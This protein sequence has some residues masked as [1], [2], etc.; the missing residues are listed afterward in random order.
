M[1]VSLPQCTSQQI[2]GVTDTTLL[3]SL[4][5]E[6]SVAQ[7]LQEALEVLNILNDDGYG[8]GRQDEGET[9]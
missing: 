6:V 7:T 9:I 8:N 4:I 3:E 5:A 1:D 2:S